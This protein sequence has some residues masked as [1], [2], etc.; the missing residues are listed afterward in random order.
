MP[1]IALGVG[2]D[3]RPWQGW[4]TQPGG[5]T[6]QDQLQAALAQ[7]VGEPVQTICAGRTDSGVHAT[8]Q[9]VH[10][11]VDVQRS[12]D[13]WVRGV[14]SFLPDSIAVQWARVVSESFHARFSATARAYTYIILNTPTRQP[15]WAHRAGW[16]FRPLDLT[17]MQ[18]AADLLIGEH[19]FSS[20]RSS[21]CQAPSP[22]RVMHDIKVQRCGHL[23]IVRLTANAFLHHMVRNIIGELVLLGVGKTDLSHF[24]SVFAGRDRTQAAPTF[25]PGGLYLT[26]VSYPEELLE[27]RVRASDL[28]DMIDSFV[29]GT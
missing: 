18:A 26:E 4:Q 22:V 21:Q 1:R 11:D 9:V 5:L 6:V 15:L 28:M 20:F 14:N 17:R 7:F 2:Y 29:P 24:K 25:A 12:D 23:V 3:G 10:F 13:A 27:R 19:D 8:G 16:C